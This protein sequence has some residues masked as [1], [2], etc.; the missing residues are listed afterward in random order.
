MTK[1]LISSVLVT[2]FTSF[3]FAGTTVQCMSDSYRVIFAQDGR[4]ATVERSTFREAYTEGKLT[5]PSN[6]VGL[7]CQR[8][9]TVLIGAT[10]VVLEC[11]EPNLKWGSYVIELT[12]GDKRLNTSQTV[13]IS[14]IRVENGQSF[15]Y[16]ITGLLCR[17]I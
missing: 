6:P 1:T 10:A 15:P 9:E 8:P 17:E 2:L 13:R 11:Q 14:E 7:N 4:T 12:Q 3:S 16:P 5:R